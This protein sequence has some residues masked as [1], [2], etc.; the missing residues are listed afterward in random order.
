MVQYVAMALELALRTMQRPSAAFVSRLESD[1]A[2][3]IGMHS[4][5]VVQHCIRCLCASVERVSRNRQLL[6][7]LLGRFYGAVRGSRPLAWACRC[8]H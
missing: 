2:H 5:L 6:Y 8:T 1:L 4:Q 7:D 3:A